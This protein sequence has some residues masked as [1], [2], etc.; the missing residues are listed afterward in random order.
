[1]FVFEKME[2]LKVLSDSGQ[3]TPGF[4]RSKNILWK[5]ASRTSYSQT[6]VH[7]IIILLKT[8]AH[9]HTKGTLCFTGSICVAV[10]KNESLQK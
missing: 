2:N 6:L 3:N 9:T 4:T 8:H 1:M 10:A 7:D 5:Q